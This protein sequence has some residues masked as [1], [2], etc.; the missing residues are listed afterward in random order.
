MRNFQGD[1]PDG[2]LTCK[3]TFWKVLDHV[4]AFLDVLGALTG[5]YERTR[6]DTIEPRSVARNFR[7]HK[8]LSEVPQELS[9]E[10]VDLGDLSA[11]RSML[12]EVL[13]AFSEEYGASG[14]G[15]AL[16]STSFTAAACC[17]CLLLLLLCPYLPV[18]SSFAMTTSVLW[19]IY[20]RHEGRRQGRPRAAT[21]LEHR[22]PRE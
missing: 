13:E 1:A 18:S 3:G 7:G 22:R 14:F 15:R 10:L 2:R 12:P 21:V 19:R 4:G 8:K 20:T 6:G 9:G 17:C 5:A 16:T 11:S